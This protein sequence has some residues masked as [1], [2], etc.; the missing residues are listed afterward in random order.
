[1]KVHLLED[2]V[3]PFQLQN[4][5]RSGALSSETRDF[6]FQKASHFVKIDAA[7]GALPRN[8]RFEQVFKRFAQAAGDKRSFSGNLLDDASR[9]KVLERFPDDR[10]T[11]S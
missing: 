1:M 9:R 3:D 6:D 4:F 10:S 5:F 8:A 11:Y 2:G 7:G